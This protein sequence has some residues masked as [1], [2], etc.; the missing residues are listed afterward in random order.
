MNGCDTFAYVEDTLVKAHHDANPDA[1]PTK[2]FGYIVNAMP[3]YFNRMAESNMAILT[4]LADE[5]LSYFEILRR[6]DPHQ[7]ALVVGEED[8]AWLPKP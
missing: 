8:N 2:Y 1:A 6:N 4:S 5:E 7:K 3:S